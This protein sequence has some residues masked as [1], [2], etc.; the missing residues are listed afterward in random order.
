MQFQANG[1][2]ANH[3]NKWVFLSA[4]Y[5]GTNLKLYRDGVE[6]TDGQE[7]GRTPGATVTAIKNSG[8]GLG[9][10]AGVSGN[11][12]FKG[13]I[14][15]VKIYNRA[16]TAEEI[17]GLYILGLIPNCGD[18]IINGR[19]FGGELEICDGGSQ[20][21]TTSNGQPG[22]QTCNSQCN[23]WD[24][25]VASPVSCESE[26]RITS[27]SSPN[28]IILTNKIYGDKIVW[29]GLKSGQREFHIYMYNLS[30]GTET[31]IT[32]SDGDQTNPAIYG[33]KI[34]WRDNRSGH[35]DIYMYKISDGSE[36][37]ITSDDLY[38][39]NP[40][41]YGDKIVWSD[42]K[43]IYMYDSN[44]NINNP[45]RQI[46]SYTDDKY[47]P[48]PVIYGDK[49][50]YNNMRSGDYDIYIYNLSIEDNP[51]TE[52]DDAETRIADNDANQMS[53]A[54]YGDKILWHD[55]RS[56]SNNIYMYDLSCTNQK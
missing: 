49:I 31:Q 39:M 27:D 14:D 19:L 55:N 9:I 46:T 48:N 10:G 41:I 20:S 4:T 56:G 22:T 35:V 23:G 17:Q 7:V 26:R 24:S 47:Q 37:N 16:L 13:K 42:A 28:T 18:G 11:A 15:D 6:I 25:C 36:T 3:K 51:A 21:C 52:G 38:Q 50:V 30:D 53:P 32:T 5:N 44:T 8:A 1:A 45:K 54:I 29:S 43:N 33:D 40:A 12:P 2:L 34:V